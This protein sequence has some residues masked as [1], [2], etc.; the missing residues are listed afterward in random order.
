MRKLA[1]GSCI[2][3]NM[4]AED[5][6]WLSHCWQFELSSFN[7]V[8]DSTFSSI[9]KKVHKKFNFKESY[10]HAFFFEMYGGATNDTYTCIHITGQ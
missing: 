7:R 9:Y 8:L 1:D 5:N 2:G 3:E 6:F 4:V 10:G